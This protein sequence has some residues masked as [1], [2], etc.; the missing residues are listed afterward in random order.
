VHLRLHCL[1]HF[2]IAVVLVSAAAILARAQAP[3]D[4]PTT[5]PAQSTPGQAAAPA[6]AVTIRGHIADQTGALIPG[7]KITITDEAGNTVRTLTADAGGAY[8][9]RGLKAGSYIVQAEYTGFAPFQSQP[10]TVSA[11]QAKRVD[12]AMAIQ[13]EQQ[14]IVV[15]DET[16]TVNVEAAGNS[17]AIVL[18]GKDL[19][20]LSDDPDELANELSALAGP[21]AGPNGGQIFIDGFSGGQLPPK[22]AIR[23]IRINQNPFSAEFDKLGYGRIEILTKPGTDKLHGQFF[24]MG[25]AKSFNTSNPF[26]QTVPSYYSYH[27]NGTVSGAINKNTSFF[28]A[29]E[30][31][32]IG[33]IDAW[34]IPDAIVQDSSGAYTDLQN[35]GVNLLN[36][37]IRTNISA[38][39]DR[40]IGARNTFTGRYSFWSEGEQGD[41][42]AGSLPSASWH[43]S[44]TDHTFQMSEAFVI[45]DHMVTE[46]RFQYERQ[47]ENHYPDSTARTVTITGDMTGGGLSTQV[48]RDHATR[49]EFQNLTTLSHG[50]HAI[51]FGTR[52]RDT[53]DA[54]F[55]TSNFNGNFHFADPQ[56]YLNMENGLA[57]GQSFDT[58]AAQGNGPISLSYTAGPPSIVANVFDAALFVQDDWKVNSRFTLSGGIRWES[59]NHVADHNDWAPRVGMAYALDGGHGKPAKTV[60]RAGFGIFYDR[61]ASTNLRTLYDSSVQNKIVLNNPVCSDTS[62]SSL[63]SL[64]VSTCQSG[65][66]AFTNS[67]VPVRYRIDDSYRS[68]YTNQVGVGLERQLNK[69]SNMTVTY[70]HS[71]GP[72]QLVTINA[73][74]FDPLTNSYPLD[75][76]GGY[77]Y[78]FYPEAVFKQDQLITS[79]NARVTKNLSLVGFYTLGYAHSDGGAGSNAS[80]ADNLSQDY[81]PATFNSRN[82]IFTMANYQGPWGLRFNPFLIAQSGK[83]FNV[84]L[85]TDPMN[86][87]YNQRPGLATA[88]QCQADASRYIATS[89]FGCLDSQPGPGEALVPANMGNG[90]AAVAVNLRVSR[91]WGFGPEAGSSS[92]QNGSG[93]GPPDGGGGGGGRRGGPPGGSLGPGGLGGGGGRGMGGMFGGGPSGRKY[94]LTFSV[95]AL[96]LFNNIDYG[97]PNGVLGTRRFDRS[98]TLAGGIFSTGS[99][100]RRVFAQA[101]FSF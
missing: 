97:G 43:E 98:T 77:I 46:T 11:G 16:P 36:T 47:N 39:I 48:Y 76:S 75:G 90:P 44:N 101:I 42:N 55:T 96:N 4:P 31:R 68:P 19:D 99:A 10:I 53:R 67:A 80:N 71:F 82:Q 27:F 34:L 61:F 81:G 29:G 49:L 57:A 79:V 63:D 30:R 66:G 21:S 1:I 70:L 41:L 94:S 28:V 59:Q 93:G 18:K 88:A 7:A 52:L 89:Q 56:A 86:D 69:G 64:N 23:E 32:H 85:A 6:A 60:L 83:P 37:R 13:A 15:T 84:T 87:F 8:E 65:P 51:K 9:A 33:N 3:A 5:A 26:T 45:N 24:G 92:G 38:R 72:H 2:Y 74:Q 50:T 14:N 17:N 12:I 54:N 62:A 40:Q 20:A 73:N 95:Q 100:A 58:L 91:G 25:N 35:Y 78:E 22:S